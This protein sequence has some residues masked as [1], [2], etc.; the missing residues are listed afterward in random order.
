MML[1]FESNHPGP[2]SLAG[3]ITRYAAQVMHAPM[4]VMQEAPLPQLPMFLARAY[5]F[6]KAEIAGRT[7]L[8]MTPNDEA[9]IT[10]DVVKHVRSVEEQAQSTVILGLA[11]VNARLRSRLIAQRVSFIVPDNQFYVPDLGM[12]LREHFRTQKARPADGL[13]PAGQAVLFHYLLRRNEQATT[14]SEIAAGLLYSPMSV[15]R[16][17]DE[18]VAAGLAASEKHGRE[19][20]LLFRHDRREL[21]D[22]ARPLLRS[23]VRSRKLVWGPHGSPPLRL[24]GESGLAG[25]TDLS[26]PKLQT[27][28]I[29]ATEWRGF[30]ARHDYREGDSEEPDFAVETWS[31]DPAGLS[32]GEIVDPLSLYAQFHDH[33]DARVR[34]AAEQL[35]HLGG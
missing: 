4:R 6:L 23:P 22:R 33:E 30:A 35:K 13:S 34:K 26:P 9:D 24:A 21:I 2:Q 18:L 27:F 15:G 32:D 8:L 11:A 5:S 29:L 17:F 20:H 16:A 28:A 31:Y 10:G 3:R 14:P 1:E 19:R 7:C 12:D 25:M